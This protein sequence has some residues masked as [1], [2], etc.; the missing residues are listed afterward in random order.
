[1]SLINDYSFHTQ[2]V[3]QR[4]ELMARATEDGLAR[5]M[6]TGSTSWWRRV[7]GRRSGSVR[8]VAGGVRAQQHRVAH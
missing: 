7:V 6:K 3:Q 1:M 2:Y 5:G 8:A 4:M